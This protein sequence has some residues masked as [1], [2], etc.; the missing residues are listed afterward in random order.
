MSGLCL[1]VDFTSFL[2]SF[3]SD[4]S[5]VDLFFPT[6]LPSMWIQQRDLMSLECPVIGISQC[7]KNRSIG[8]V[9][10]SAVL[11]YRCMLDRIDV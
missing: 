7:L 4:E 11:D 2:L 3:S 9:Q 10:M 1:L 5:N 6:M 8:H